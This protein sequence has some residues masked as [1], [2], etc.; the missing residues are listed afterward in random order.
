MENTNLCQHDR[1][2]T[3]IPQAKSIDS[4]VTDFAPFVGQSK[5]EKVMHEYDIRSYWLQG[6]LANKLEVP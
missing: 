1:D 6:E 5:E 3:P 2:T 4:L